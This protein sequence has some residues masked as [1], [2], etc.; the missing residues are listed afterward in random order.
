MQN[1]AEKAERAKMF[2]PFD[3]LKGFRDYL[4][5]K[6]RILVEKKELSSDDYERLNRTMQ[7]IRIGSMIKVVYYDQGDYVEL[8]GMVCKLDAQIKRN[9]QIVNTVISLED[10][11]EVYGVEE[12]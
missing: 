3:S 10:I 1:K 8:E 5:K 11:I 2:L 7:Q 12:V 9:I 6:E 4:K